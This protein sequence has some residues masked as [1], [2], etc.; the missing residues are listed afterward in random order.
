[1]LVSENR[2]SLSV[3]T[4]ILVF[5]LEQKVCTVKQIG[6]YCTSEYNRRYIFKLLN[7]L[8]R[9]GF[10]SI[11]SVSFDGQRARRTVCL[12]SSGL[13]QVKLRTGF[14]LET[15]QIKSNYPFHDVLL[16]SVRNQFSKIKDCDV[17]LSENVLQSKILESDIPELTLFR[18]YR[19]DAVV[20]LRIDGSQV[21]VPLEVER[22]HKTSARYRERIKKIYQ[23]DSLKAVFVIAES[24]TL[25]NKLI[26]IEK[27]IYPN[28]KRRILFCDL[29]TLMRSQAGVRFSTTDGVPLCL[30]MSSALNINYPILDHGFVDSLQQAEH[31]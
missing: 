6:A 27:E 25:K 12:T 31:F 23:T 17:F 14:N 8:H 3:D 21:W 4:R 22:S 24:N 20:H 15:I 11:D 29:P 26:E 5:L 30:E 7:K 9:A 28:Q 1:M 18:A 19:V 10:I 2:R 13:E 16:T